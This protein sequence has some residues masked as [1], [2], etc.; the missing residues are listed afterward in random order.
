MKGIQFTSE[1]KQLLIEA[2]LFSSNTDVCAE[3][4][5]KI[6]QTM[7]ELAKRL[8]EDKGPLNNIY[9]FESPS[10]ESPERLKL[11]KE[12]FPNL[13]INNSEAIEE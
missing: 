10:F 13:P 5:P 8:N 7:I 12:Q 11:L 4:N 1:E 3:W 6:E 9:M 2:L